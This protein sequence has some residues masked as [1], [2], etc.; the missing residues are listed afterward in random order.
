[1]KH[2]SNFMMYH[3]PTETGMT[4]VIRFIGNFEADVFKHGLAVKHKVFEDNQECYEEMLILQHCYDSISHEMIIDYNTMEI[5]LGVVFA[6]RFAD[7][8]KN[9]DD[10]ERWYEIINDWWIRQK[11]CE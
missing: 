2:T 1:M 4:P 8:F 7:E 3:E 11:D 6:V 5:C 9:V 10:L